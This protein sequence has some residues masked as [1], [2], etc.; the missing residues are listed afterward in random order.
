MENEVAWLRLVA[1]VLIQAMKDARDGR[2]EA[3]W[4]L[5]SEDCDCF[6]AAL[7]V[8]HTDVLR[9]LEGDRVLPNTSGPRRGVG[10]G[11]KDFRTIQ[12][13]FGF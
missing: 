10:R 9:W 7:G 13:T 6:C 3:E 11:E 5:K 2:Y 1:G 4:W 8:E 12:L